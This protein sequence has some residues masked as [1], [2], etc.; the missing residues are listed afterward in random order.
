VIKAD[1]ILSNVQKVE[2]DSRRKK[3]KNEILKKVIKNI[4]K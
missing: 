1:E 4:I 3:N 2:S